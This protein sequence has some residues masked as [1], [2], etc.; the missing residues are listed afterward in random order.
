MELE[1]RTAELRDLDKSLNERT[2]ALDRLM[3]EEAYL[4]VNHEGT[5]KSLREIQDAILRSGDSF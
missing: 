5:R 1:K 3:E 4:K 2:R